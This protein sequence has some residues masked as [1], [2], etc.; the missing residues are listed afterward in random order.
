[1]RIIPTILLAYLVIAIQSGL[2]PFIAV[3]D[4][5][6]NLMLAVVIF[7]ALYAPREAALIGVYVLGLMQD[8]LSQEPLGAH[9]LVYAAVA[10]ATR[11]TQPSIHREHWLTHV[12]LAM[13]GAAL[14]AVILWLAG[15]RLPPQPAVDLLFAGALYSVILTPILLRVLI[16]MR[17]IF[18]YSAHKK[19]EARPI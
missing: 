10:I 15:L 5:T 9:A 16:A 13:M 2:A 11:F 19:I 18:I 3:R 17:R 14:H 7:I 8:V 6:P 12:L 1:M 4:A